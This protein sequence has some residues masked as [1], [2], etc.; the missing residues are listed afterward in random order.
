MYRRA[1]SW[2]GLGFIYNLSECW[3]HVDLDTMEEMESLPMPHRHDRMLATFLAKNEG[4]VDLLGT[5][6]LVPSSP[7]GALMSAARSA[8][9]S[10]TAMIYTKETAKEFHTL[11]YATFAMFVTTLC[12]VHTDF[13]KC[14]SQLKD[15]FN[16]ME[17]IT[18]LLICVLTSSSFKKHI[19]LCTQNG[20]V[21]QRLIPSFGKRALY[22]LFAES[23]V[24]IP[25]AK[26]SKDILGQNDPKSEAQV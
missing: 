13:E 5:V 23:L 14:D 26:R 20:G 9:R 2:Q 25:E 4:L 18:R 1:T 16:M 11:L 21:L 15:S 7:F 6:K 19:R 22:R 24:I 8:A 17:G 3:K 12:D 10:G